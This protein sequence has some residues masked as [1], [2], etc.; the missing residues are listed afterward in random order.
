M[1]HSESMV[2]QIASSMLHR[3][4]TTLLPTSF[5]APKTMLLPK[6][7]YYMLQYALH[8]ENDGHT[9]ELLGHMGK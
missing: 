5:M 4:P 2:E 7:E 1:E 6:C 9:E 8:A 3:H